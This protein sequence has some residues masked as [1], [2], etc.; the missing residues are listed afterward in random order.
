MTKCKG[1]KSKIK[2]ELDFCPYCGEAQRG[3]DSTHL[4]LILDRSGS[5]SSVK[6]ATIEGFN[7][8]ISDQKR[9]PLPATISLYQFDDIYEP[10]YENIDLKDAKYLDDNIYQP[11]NTTALFDAIGK[12]INSYVSH[13]TSLSVKERPKKVLFCIITDGYENASKEF[14]SKITVKNLM[15][16][17][18][19]KYNWQFSFVGAGIDAYKEAESYGI[20]RGQTMKVN[21]SSEG[22]NHFFHDHSHATVS[23]RS[24]GDNFLY[25]QSKTA[26]NTD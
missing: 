6:Q 18:K 8:F 4:V 11:R 10:V 25:N 1:C 9:V 19:S 20:A 2:K 21:A 16:T 3:K 17:V 13:Y 14:T 5:M 12:T 26:T 7:Q 22:M 15:D 24:T 23:Y